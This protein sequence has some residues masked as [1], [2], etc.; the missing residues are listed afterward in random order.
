[1]RTGLIGHGLGGRA[2]HEPLIR[3]TPRLAL[4]GIATTRSNPDPA[5]LIADPEIGLIVISTPNVT[6]YPLARAALE[7]GKHVVIDKPFTVTLDEADELIALAKA[8]QRVLTIFHNRRWD[9]DFLTVRKLLASGVLGELLRYESH[10]DRFRPA[11]KPGWKEQAAP[12]AGVLSDLG[13]H[14]VDQALLL[15]GEPDWLVGDVERQ[16][17]GT[18]VEDYF[19]VTFG[20]GR[21]RAILTSSLLAAAPRP[22]FALHGTL[23]SFV[24]HGLDPQE[25]QAQAGMM[26]DDPA[27][28]VEDERW[29]GILTRA[30][31]STEPIPT[32]RGN[33][34][35]F[36]EGVAAAILDGAP[37]PV[38]PADA[39]AG[40]EII[41]QVRASARE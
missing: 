33:Y 30:D 37:V 7:A 22:R 40:L 16:R 18:E 35:A 13:P 9:G 29:H 26:P 4:A 19:A 41:D 23:G 21:K 32:E 6:H 39:R 31:G 17:A 27:F 34:L 11:I 10:W 38:E 1:M 28:G 15:F 3:A 25:P 14:L 2:F 36:Y 20:Y 24:K 8:Q 5:G 12:G